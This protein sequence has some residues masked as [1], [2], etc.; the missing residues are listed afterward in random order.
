MWLD[1]GEG[2]AREDLQEGGRLGCRLGEETKN[3]EWF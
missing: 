2:V 1:H 3:S